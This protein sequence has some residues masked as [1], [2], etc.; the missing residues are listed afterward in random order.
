MDREV[1]A[2]GTGDQAGVK[3]GEM[4]ER[5]EQCRAAVYEKGVLRFT[6]GKL[7]FQMHDLKRRCNNR[8]AMNGLCLRHHRCGAAVFDWTTKGRSDATAE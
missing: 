5:R 7:R 8:A 3:G 1:A 4:S 6:G 2:C